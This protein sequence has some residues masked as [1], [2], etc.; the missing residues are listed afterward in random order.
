MKRFSPIFLASYWIITILSFASAIMVVLFY[1]PTEATMGHIQKIFYLHL[2]SA[3]CTFLACLITFVASIGYLIQRKSVW[4]DLASAAARVA[5]QLC[6]VVLLTGMI[7]GRSAWGQWWTWSPRL[8]FVLVLWLL[9]V[10]Y[11]V[12]RISVESSQRRA[13]IS[14]VYGI[15][16]FLDVPLVYLSVHLMPDIHPTSISLISPMKLTLGIWFIPVMLLTA[17]LIVFRFR[18]NTAQRAIADAE[19][20][21]E[22]APAPLRWVGGAL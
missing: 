15:L 8:T 5:V 1:V 17:G 2:P 13:V 18:L 9:Y 11:L 16:A 12:V 22:S 10:V 21:E 20:M 14:A 7:W 6:T 3:I 19:P 4:D